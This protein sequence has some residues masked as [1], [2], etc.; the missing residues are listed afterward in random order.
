MKTIAYLIAAVMMASIFGC[1]NSCLPSNKQAGT[2]DITT[3]GTSKDNGVPLDTL[4]KRL[5]R[6]G[7]LEISGDNEAETASYFDTTKFEFH[8]PDSAKMNYAKMAGYFKSLRA[9]FDDLTIKRGV[10]VKQGNYIACQ[11]WI[12]GTFAREF[13]QSLVGKL[14][15]N[16]KKVVFALINI[17]RFDSQ[18]RIVETWSQADNRSALRQL[19]AKGQ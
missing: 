15:P 18:G 5:I 2:G 4:E 1:G 14:P 12:E 7:K 19:G 13:T 9:A 11:T 6:A 17:Y 8:G 3:I 16:G 10:I